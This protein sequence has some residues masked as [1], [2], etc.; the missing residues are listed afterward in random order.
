MYEKI[1][2]KEFAT[3]DSAGL[4]DVDFSN[5]LYH[6]IVIKK[7]AEKKS[8]E[9]E[10]KKGTKNTET[11]DKKEVIETMETKEEGKIQEKEKE[12]K[13][14]RKKEEHGTVEEEKEKEKE[15]EHL[16]AV[17]K[18]ANRERVKTKC[19]S[20]LKASQNS[21]QPNQSSS[22]CVVLTQ[23]EHVWSGGRSLRVRGKLEIHD[24]VR[25]FSKTFFVLITIV[26]GI[27]S[28]CL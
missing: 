16:S 9:I 20:E 2:V 26:L 18:R 7:S 23:D 10:D 15:G 22:E 1:Y 5:S 21:Y 8:Y 28:I 13:E 24:Q 17:L 25:G 3:R 12:E 6:F 11:G 27:I 14:E 19:N 4:C